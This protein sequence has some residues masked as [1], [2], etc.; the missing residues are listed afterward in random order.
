MLDK[1]AEMLG[2]VRPGA[3]DESFA[4]EDAMPVPK[5]PNVIVFDVNETLLDLTTLVPVFDRI[6]GKAEKMREWFAQLI[7]YSQAMTLSGLYA[8]FGELASATLRM[9]GET[10]GVHI[11]DDDVHDL[12][13]GVQSMPV[14]PDV[15][16]ALGRLRAAG[17]RLVTLT[18]SAPVTSPTPLERAGISIFFERNFS[19]HEVGRF[20]PAPECYGMVVSDLGV[21]ASDLCVVACHL[22]DTI[23]AQAGGCR[24]ALIKR[25]GNAV[26]PA[27]NVP[28]PDI[29]VD[30]MHAF[31]DAAIARWAPT[32]VA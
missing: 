14:L 19:V 31:A 11:A 20:K 4:E 24:A 17:F 5:G 12:M 6:F 21:R 18:N 8:P 1:S 3:G 7:L 13:H 28:L 23:G 10:S 25:P 15:V 9:I 2:S 26:L 16:P 22:W 27:P 32:N 29:V 30:D